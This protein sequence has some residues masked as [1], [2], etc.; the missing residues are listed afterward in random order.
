MSWIEGDDGI[1]TAAPRKVD[2]MFVTRIDGGW[3]S[4]GAELHLLPIDQE[5]AEKD[6][7]VLPGGQQVRLMLRSGQDV[8]IFKQKRGRQ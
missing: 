8:F 3:S 4:E 7:G 1:C 5:R 6:I 2:D